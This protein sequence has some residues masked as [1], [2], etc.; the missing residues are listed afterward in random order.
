VAA[1]PVGIAEA[2][3][4]RATMCDEVFRE[5]SYRWREFRRMRV[6]VKQAKR[7]TALVVRAIS[8]FTKFFM[9]RVRGI[10]PPRPA[11]KAGVLPLNYTRTITICIC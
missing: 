6:P 5:D 8:L 9:E 4:I 11:W 3:Q 2:L 7:P 1:V 10:E